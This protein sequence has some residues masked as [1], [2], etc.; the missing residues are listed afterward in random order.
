MTATFKIQD[1][2]VVVSSSSG[3]PSLVVDKPKL[4]QDVR[5]MLGQR[6]GTIGVG[7]DDVVGIVADAF[8]IRADISRRI[9]RGVSVIQTLQDRFHANQRSPEERI[10]GI[11]SLQV[12]GTVQNGQSSRTDYAFRV[13]ISSVAGTLTTMSGAVQ[14]GN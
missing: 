11:A 6:G 14:V 8:V 2:D 4:R 13:S 3:R 10:S 12:G 9:R 7:L 1:G 5:Q